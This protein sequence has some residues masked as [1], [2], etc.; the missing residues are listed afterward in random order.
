M[1][2]G[3]R[4]EKFNIVSSDHGRTHKCD[5]SVF[6][7]KLLFWAN[8]VKKIK[9]VS[10][11]W[12]LVPR[13]IRTWRIYRRCWFIRFLTGIA[14]FGQTWSKNQNCQF[15]VKFITKTNSNMQN[16]IVCLSWNLAPRLIQV[17]RI[18][19]CVHIFFFIWE[20]PFSGK[21]GPKN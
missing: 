16:S 18:S 4:V 5:F 11:T 13:L 14:G 3:P 12:N 21:F 8:L 20:T 7:R 17:Y 10:L 1:S 19:W 6:D 15:K 2:V 9:I